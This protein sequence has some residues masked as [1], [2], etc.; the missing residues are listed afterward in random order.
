MRLTNQ[1]TVSLSEIGESG[2]LGF[3]GGY[4]F[5]ET[6]D[7]EGVADAAVTTY[8]T[9]S[10]ALA[11]ELDGDAHQGGDPGAINLGNAIEDHDNFAGALGD[12]RFQG[13]V[14]LF[15]GFTDG[16]TAV[17]LENGDGAAIA[18]LDFHWSVIGHWQ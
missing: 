16:E 14:K 2:R 3:E 8:E 18:N 6:G 13:I 1:R 10:A 12:Y 4:G 15:A 11:S 7:R 17:Y 9:E 5:D